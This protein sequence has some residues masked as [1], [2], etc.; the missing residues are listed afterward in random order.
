MLHLDLGCTRGT[1]DLMLF[2]RNGS[3]QRLQPRR[4]VTQAFG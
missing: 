3:S 1:L 4:L 2:E